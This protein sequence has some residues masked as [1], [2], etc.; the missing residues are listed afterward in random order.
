MGELGSWG[1][2]RDTG[3]GEGMKI[4]F[5]R[6]G[7]SK[8]GVLYKSFYMAQ[9]CIL[10]T[11]SVIMPHKGSIDLYNVGEPMTSCPRIEDARYVGEHDGVLRFDATSKGEYYDAVLQYQA[12]D[13]HLKSV[14]VTKKYRFNGSAYEPS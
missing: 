13:K 6:T 12:T 7:S 9:G 10:I 11:F 14:T 8:H 4:R 2:W 1:E 5:V 3:D